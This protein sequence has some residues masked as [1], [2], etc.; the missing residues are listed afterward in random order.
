MKSLNEQIAPKFLIQAR[1][2]REF[3]KLLKNVIPVEC[4]DHVQV[5]NIRQNILMLITDSPVWTTRLRQLSPQ[6]LQHIHEN[7]SK[8]FDCAI[9]NASSKPQMIHHIQIRTRYHTA[10]TYEQQPASSEQRETPGISKK[11]ADLLTQSANSIDDLKLKTALLKVASHCKMS[12]NGEFSNKQQTQKNK[13][14][15]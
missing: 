7:S 6:I 10:N 9:Q 2:L 13:P 4:R 3:E 8:L 5:A 12:T 14:E 15:R 1:K 11:T